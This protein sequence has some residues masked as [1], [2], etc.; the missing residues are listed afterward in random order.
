MKTLNAEHIHFEDDG[1]NYDLVLV[2]DPYG[3]SDRLS[4]EILCR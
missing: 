4:L 2:D 1:T 3:G